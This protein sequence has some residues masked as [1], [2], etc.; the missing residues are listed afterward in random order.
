MF[1]W[2]RR[3]W[4]DG[5]WREGGGWGPTDQTLREFF[6]EPQIERFHSAKGDEPQYDG[7]FEQLKLKKN[8]GK[9]LCLYACEEGPRSCWCAFSRLVAS[10]CSRCSPHPQHDAQAL[11]GA[12]LDNSLHWFGHTLPKQ[13]AGACHF[14]S[15]SPGSGTGIMLR[16]LPRPDKADAATCLKFRSMYECVSCDV[17]TS[18]HEVTDVMGR[19]VEVSHVV[20]PS[21]A[22]QWTQACPL[23]RVICINVM[24][25]YADTSP[26]PGCSYVGLFHIR[27]EVLSA[28][29]GD[30]Q[31]EPSIALFQKFCSGPAGTPSVVPLPT[32]LDSDRSLYRRRDTSKQIKHN[33]GLVKVI[34]L[35]ENVT[36]LGLGF[37]KRG[38]VNSFNGKPTTITKSG[39]IIQQNGPG[40]PGEWLEIGVDVK[41]NY[42]NKTVKHELR[43]NRQVLRRAV[44]HIG[45]VIQGVEDGELPEGLVLDMH[46]NGVNTIDVRMI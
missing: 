41:G 17:I 31:P 27:P 12:Q 42:F 23:P 38:L 20:A 30:V 26:D 11:A 3:R 28:L 39:Y 18:T 4:P 32:E 37:I 2:L 29:R 45:L 21:A 22:T 35:C 1:T 6:D 7:I 46:L 13:A 34:G 16:T 5:F 14:P 44:G 10:M 19:L 8:K 24:L 25:P 40:T 9:F 33:S 15:W 43:S 36:D